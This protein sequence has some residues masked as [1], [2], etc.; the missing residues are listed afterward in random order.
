M[1]TNHLWFPGASQGIHWLFWPLAHPWKILS[2]CEMVYQ[3]CFKH[4]DFVTEIEVIAKFSG[5]PFDKIIFLNFMYEYFTF[6][7]C[8]EILVRNSSSYAWK[9]PWFRNVGFLTIIS[10]QFILI[11]YSPF[12][13]K[14]LTHD[15]A[16]YPL[17]STIFKYRTW[18]PE[19][20][21]KGS[22]TWRSLAVFCICFCWEIQ[23]LAVWTQHSSH[24]IYDLQIVW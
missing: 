13:I 24:I 8:S 3:K 9:E 10:D 6:K 11:W 7:A 1:E 17:L 12:I 19:T 4:K 20:V 14:Y 18:N 2:R 21:K 15:D 22:R 16:L 5:H 23:L